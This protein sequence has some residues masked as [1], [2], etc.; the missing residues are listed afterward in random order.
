MKLSVLSLLLV[1]AGGIAA[2][3]VEDAV[4]VSELETESA[5]DEV[6]TFDADAGDVLVLSADDVYTPDDTDGRLEIAYENDGGTC[7]STLTDSEIET[8]E[9][10][11]TTDLAVFNAQSAATI[12][13]ADAKRSAIPVVWH[14]IYSTKTVAGGYI[15]NSA[16]KKSISAINTHFKGSGFGFT[17][18][19][20]KRKKNSNW[21]KKIRI[22]PD[23]SK[24]MKTALHVGGAGTLNIYSVDFADGTIGYGR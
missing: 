18:K 20:I 12:A 2:I 6:T 13:S 7:G 9:S 1:I 24:G 10:Q 4:E 16:V 19:Q 5:L 8:I 3:P 23:N 17:L 11:L 14:V 22:D 21:F 15:S